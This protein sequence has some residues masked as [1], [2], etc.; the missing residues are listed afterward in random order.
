LNS[1]VLK[2]FLSEFRPEPIVVPGMRWRE[3]NV[4]L[5]KGEFHANLCVVLVRGGLGLCTSI[6]KLSHL[7]V[8]NAV[9]ASDIDRLYP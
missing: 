8:G 5:C 4:S 6:A 2:Y 1:A 7:Q 9:C 3:R